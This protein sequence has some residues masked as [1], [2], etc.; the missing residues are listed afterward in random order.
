MGTD[1]GTQVKNGT[2]GRVEVT[3]SP[4]IACCLCSRKWSVNR[5][6][7]QWSIPPPDVPGHRSTKRRPP[8]AS[9]AGPFGPGRS[10]GDGA[11]DD[12]VVG[13]IRPGRDADFEALLAV[14]NDAARVYRGVIPDD[15]WSE[16]YMPAEELA[17]E[18]AAGVDFWVYEE[19]REVTGMMGLQLAGDVVLIR[20]AYVRT[21]QQGRG[22][23]SALLD[24]LVARTH[25]PLLVG[26]WAAATWAIRFYERH[27]FRLVPGSRKNA[28]LDRYWSIPAR[29]TEASVVLADD[30]W[31]TGQE[32]AAP[33]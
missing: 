7:F 1:R 32:T 33:A 28:V 11:C 26:T 17:G 23:G 31:W 19:D 2:P 22:I 30:R 13:M 27:G 12:I 29:Q 8:T 25:A 6:A 10:T 9:F 18:I 21:A 5:S 24:A 4:D 14:V 3:R 16:P 20:H 15:C